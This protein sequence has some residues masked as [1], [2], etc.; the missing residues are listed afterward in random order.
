MWEH[1]KR[2]WSRPT[3]GPWGRALLWSPVATA[4]RPRAIASSAACCRFSATLK[5]HYEKPR[6]PLHSR[7][8]PVVKDIWRLGTCAAMTRW[9]SCI[10]LHFGQSQS[11]NWQLRLWPWVEILILIKSHIFKIYLQP[12]NKAMVPTARTFRLASPF[13]TTAVH[14]G[15]GH[16]SAGQRLLL[17]FGHKG[18]FERKTCLLPPFCVFCSGSQGRLRGWHLHPPPETSPPPPP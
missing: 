17:I 6:R 12:W 4:L 11:R 16:I 5:V 10:R 15:R 13:S 8:H 3:M 7:L 9:R 2:W 1:L 14:Q 18:S